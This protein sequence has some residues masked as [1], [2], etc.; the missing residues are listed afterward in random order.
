M[1][2]LRAGWIITGRDLAHWARQPWGLVFKLAFSLMLLLMFGLLF[3][4][5]MSVPGGGSYLDFLMP[6]MLTLSMMFGIEATTTAMSA[7]VAKGVTNRFRSMPIGGG[8]VALGRAGADMAG[9]VVEL[10]LIAGVGF[11]M[12]WRVDA[13]PWAMLLALVLLLALRF[14]LI[15]VGIFV[16]LTFKGSGA[17]T[18]VQVLVW[19]VGFLSSALIPTDTM[20]AWLGAAAGWNPISATANAVRDLLGSPGAGQA[21]A[22]S[23]P[24]GDLALLLAVAWPV[25]ITLVF[26]P[27]SARAYRRLGH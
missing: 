10:A 1:T 22:V 21:S 4:G 7:D 18:A 26:L 23:G 3:G 12:G 2:T 27:L 14:A 25:L 17:T 16:A 8:A 20:P 13:G 15:W 6:G 24:A 19:P 11:L 9:T 5:A